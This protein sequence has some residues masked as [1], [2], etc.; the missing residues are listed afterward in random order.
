MR[1]MRQ[2]KIEQV[3][4]IKI[5][6]VYKQEHLYWAGGMNHLIS[7]LGSLLGSVIKMKLLIDKNSLFLLDHSLIN[8]QLSYCI[9]ISVMTIKLWLKDYSSC[10]LNL[11]K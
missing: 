2:N 3:E 4:H 11:L 1:K 6:S 7:K 10:D 5:L 8:S 9:L